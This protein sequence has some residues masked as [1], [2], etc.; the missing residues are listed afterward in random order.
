MRNN[1]MP[2]HLMNA[3]AKLDK[4]VL[5]ATAHKSKNETYKKDVFKESLW[6]KLVGFFKR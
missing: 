1:F 2:V 3:N 5:A 6:T 4:H